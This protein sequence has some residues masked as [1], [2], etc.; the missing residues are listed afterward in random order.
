MQGSNFTAKIEC[1][2]VYDIE[3]HKQKSE[4]TEED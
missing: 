3:I 1:R 2:E 4:N